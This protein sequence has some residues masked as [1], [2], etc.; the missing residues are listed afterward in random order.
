MT[1]VM[2]VSDAPVSNPSACSPSLNDAVLDHSRSRRS[3]S[4]RITSSAAMH[5][6]TTA[7]GAEVEN[8]NGRPRFCNHSM[9]WCDPAMNPPSTPMAFDSV[10]TWMSTRP[11]RPK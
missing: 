5:A 6:A 3:G 8:R 7:G 1:G 9:R 10:P 2:G 11:L 4:S